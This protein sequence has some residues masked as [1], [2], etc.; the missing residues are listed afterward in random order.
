MGLGRVGY[1]PLE[2]TLQQF[3]EFVKQQLEVPAIRVVGDLQSKINR[4]ALVG[5]DGNKYIYAARRAGAD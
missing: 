4:V 1:L 3:A 2:M 5:V